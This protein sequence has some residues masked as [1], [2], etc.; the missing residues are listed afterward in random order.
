MLIP[1]ANLLP[2][3]EPVRR[4]PDAAADAELLRSLTTAKQIE[5]IIVIPAKGGKYIVKNGNRR[6]RLAPQ[7]GLEGLIA[8]V[9]PSTDE[10]FVAGAAVATNTTQARLA[11][12]DL[13]RALVR[14]QGQGHTL[15]TAAAFLGISE[16][17]AAG[18]DMLGRLAPE[19]LALMEQHGTPPEKCL[20]IIAG[21]PLDMQAKAAKN[22]A[23]MRP[24]RP[25][26]APSPDWYQV[27]RLLSRTRY[28]QADAIFDVQKVKITWQRDW[29][30]QPGDPDEITTADAD[31]FLKAQRQ[32]LADR[33]AASKGKLAQVE[34]S[35]RNPGAP[36]LPKGWEARYSADPDKPRRNEVVYACIAERTGQLVRVVAYDAAAEREAQR[37][38]EKKAQ[39]QAK[40]DAKAAPARPQLATAPE[41]AAGTTTTPAALRTAPADPP[42]PEATA[43]EPETGAP[44]TK[45]GQAMLAA[46]KTTALRAKLRH[47]SFAAVTAGDSDLIVFLILALHAKNVEIRGYD[48]PEGAASHAGADIVRRII[49][50]EGILQYDVSEVRRLACETL[51]RVLSASHPESSTYNPGSGDVAE[52]IGAAIGAESRLPALTS[53]EFLATWRAPALKEA[54]TAAGV[55]FTSV[56]Q[57]RRD[58]EGTLAP[59]PDSGKATW[60]P[61]FAQFGA[62]GPKPA[63]GEG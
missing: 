39:Q 29:L 35:T 17:R 60:C 11:P 13:W 4:V 8:H 26:D 7:A 16:R 33:A 18:L 25:G 12:V 58:L 28:H 10:A 37:A 21:A 9:L 56:A 46:L 63:S 45:A 55:K 15:A 23:I 3:P 14:M 2:D 61:T 36:E 42:E 30:A 5:P 57:A 43:P 31:R 1:L 27:E 22:K 52:W 53:A 49:T 50:P 38:K 34:E 19:M 24:L 6:L 41:S 47:P 20:R 48:R 40:A 44:I 51:A 59:D 62:P 32:A 54:A